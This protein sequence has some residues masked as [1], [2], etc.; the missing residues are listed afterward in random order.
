[1][2][3]HFKATFVCFRTKLVFPENIL[4][5]LGL[6]KRDDKLSLTNINLVPRAF[7]LKNGKGKS[8][9]DEVVTNIR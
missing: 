9:G 2:I 4:M 3:R 8:P 6:I 7:P 1:M 5:V